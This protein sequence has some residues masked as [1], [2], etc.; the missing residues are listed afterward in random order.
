MS[1]FLRPFNSKQNSYQKTEKT[2]P[3]AQLL[4]KD[5]AV[6]VGVSD[7]IERNKMQE[8][9]HTL[10]K[11]NIVYRTFSHDVNK[12]SAPKIDT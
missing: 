4:N 6:E 9:S 1:S 11:D 2:D 8:M 7:H 12:T 10:S 5:L 3:K